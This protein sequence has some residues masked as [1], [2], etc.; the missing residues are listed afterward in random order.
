MPRYGFNFQWLYNVDGAPCA[1]GPDERALDFLAEHG[2]NFVRLPTDYRFWTRGGD[3]GEADGAVL[4]AI[5]RC[6]DACAARGMQLSLN[7]HRAPGYCINRNDLERHDLW[8]DR[9]AQDAFV[10]MWERF[11]RRYRGRPNEAL[12]FDLLNEPP[13]EGSPDFPTFTRAAHEAVMRRTVAAIRAI[14]PAR[15]IVVDGL[16]GGNVPMPELADLGLVQSCRGYAPFTLTHYRASWAKGSDAWSEPAWPHVEK[17]KRWDRDELRR[18]YEPWRALER[19]GVRVHVGEFGCFNRTPNAV[20]LAWFEDLLSLY[21]EFGWGYALWGFDYS[22]GIVD[23]GRPGTIYEA[24][25]DYRL[26]RALFELYLAGR[27]GG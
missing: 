14:D 11:A 27:V 3:Y 5:D 7:L 22:F 17:G 25:K 1:A 24:Y 4:S 16:G 19:Q 21:R 18:F 2:F 6:V 23:H 8:T 13:G 26:D 12:S 10:L 15:E 20:A 9:E